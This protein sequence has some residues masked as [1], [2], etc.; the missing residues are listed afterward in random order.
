LRDYLRLLGRAGNSFLALFSGKMAV[1][2]PTPTIA[3][4]P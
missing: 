4:I 3:A 2:L 1:F